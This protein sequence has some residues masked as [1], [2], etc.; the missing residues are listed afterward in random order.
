MDILVVLILTSSELL[1]YIA[2]LVFYVI[3]IIQVPVRPKRVE[4]REPVISRQSVF[5][6]FPIRSGW[7]EQVRDDGEFSTHSHRVP[8]IVR[9]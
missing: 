8:R 4:I 1:L 7:F 9:H 5:E 2:F 3:S 6:R